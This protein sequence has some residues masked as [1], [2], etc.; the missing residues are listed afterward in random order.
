MFSPSP[1]LPE[2][3]G[4]SR[5]LNIREARRGYADGPALDPFIAHQGAEVG[6]AA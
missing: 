4:E 2:V 5:T 3:E 1:A 6:G